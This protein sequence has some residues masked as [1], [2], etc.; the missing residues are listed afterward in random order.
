MK[1]N[2]YILLVILLIV[3][4]CNTESKKDIPVSVLDAKPKNI[5]LMIGDGMG[6]SQLYAA[7]AI[8]K[9]ELNIARCRHAALVNTSS[10]DDLITDSAASGT[11]MATGNKTRNGHL[12]VD[13][14]GKILTTILE[15]AEMHNQATGLVSTSSITHATPASFIAHNPNRNDYEAIAADFL[16]TDIEVFIGGGLDYFDKRK[17][18]RKLTKNLA[19]QGY[20]VLTDPAKIT[21]YK[22]KKLAGLVYPKHGP[23]VYEGRENFL[24]NATET[25]LE[26]LNQETNGFFLMV[27][28]S[29][30]DWGGHDGDSKYVVEESL[31]FDRAVGKALD[32]ADKNGETLVIVTADHETG[33]MTITGGTLDGKNMVYH[34]STDH[35]TPVFVPLFA[36]GPGAE[37]FTGIMENTAIFDK[38]MLA[39]GFNNSK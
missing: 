23:K 16:E 39:F 9:D 29:Q 27:E 13:T 7:Y 19:K 30:I 4:A 11:A 12:S 22:G 14:N 3:S 35:H 8:K 1:Y 28:A 25:A 34:F 10:I 26:I 6:V 32:F 31:D 18:G 21:N 38:M 33:G 5:I 2:I 20:D 37:N 15:I 17:D 36:S 24:E